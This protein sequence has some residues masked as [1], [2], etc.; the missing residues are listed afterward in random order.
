M[1]NFWIFG[2]FGTIC[3][4]FSEKGCSIYSVNSDFYIVAFVPF[5]LLRWLKVPVRCV[6]CR[7]LFLKRVR[8]TRLSLSVIS[9][10]KAVQESLISSEICISIPNAIPRSRNYIIYQKPAV[11]SSVFSIALVVFFYLFHSCWTFGKFN[12]LKFLV[13]YVYCLHM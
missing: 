10:F 1:Q 7:I 12:L 3:L 9:M 5:Q 8:I 2:V 4:T 6:L 13:L 11:R